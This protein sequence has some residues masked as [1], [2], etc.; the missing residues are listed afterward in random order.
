M[1]NKKPFLSP[2]SPTMWGE[3]CFCFDMDFSIDEISAVIGVQ[4]TE[5]KRRRDCSWNFHEGVQNPGYWMIEFF[6]TDTFDSD[7]FQMGMHSFIEEY[8]NKLLEI[9]ERFQPN[10][11]FLRIYT[12]VHQDGEYPAIRLEPFFIKDAQLLNASIDIIVENDY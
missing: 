5:A 1:D 3:L 12:V 9:M 8:R 2:L 11:A 7:E 6:R 10:T 4:P